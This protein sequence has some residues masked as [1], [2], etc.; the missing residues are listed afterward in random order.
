MKTKNKILIFLTITATIASSLVFAFRSSAQVVPFV[1]SFA[2]DTLQISAYVVNTEN[3]EIANGEYDVRFAIYS[4]DRTERDP[5]PSDTDLATRLWSETQKVKLHDGILSAYLGSVTPFPA[6]LRFNQGEYYIGIRIND[7]SEMIPRKRIAAVPAAVNAMYLRGVSY[8]SNQGDLLQLGTGG[9]IDI[10]YLNTGK[11]NNQLVL[12][13]DTRLAGGKITVGGLSYIKANGMK[14][15]LGQI[16]LG[17]DVTGTLGVSEGGTGLSSI[18]AGSVLY[19]NAS[20]S[21]T[22]LTGGV[23]NDGQMLSYNWNG[24][25]PYV[26]WATATG[27]FT[28][29][30]V[31]GDNLATETIINGNTLTIA[32]GTNI[33][34]AI[35]TPDTV[36][37]N[38]NTTLS[39][40]TWQGNAIASNYLASN[41]MLEGENISLLTNNSGYITASSADTLTNKSGNISMW[42]NNSGYITASSSDTLTNKTWNG[43]VIGPIYGGT[44]LNAYATG[45]ILYASGTDTLA[46]RHAGGNGAVLQLVGGVPNWASVN[47]VVAHDLLNS[48]AHQDTKAASP[49]LGALVSGIDDSGITKWGSVGIGSAIAKS[50]L[51]INSTRD[52][53]EWRPSTDIT[54]LGTVATG[55]WN[56]TPIADNYVAN[57]ITINQG[58]ISDS[59]I[60][61]KNTTG[62]TNEGEIE[63]DATGDTIKVGDGAGSQLTFYPGQ[64]GDITAVG[65]VASGPAFTSGGN[66]GTSLYFYDPD[67][68]GQLTVGNISTDRTY[69]LP[70]SSGNVIV[71]PGAPAQG[72]V[73]FYNG[74]NWARLGY[75]S[76]GWFLKTN[77]VGADPSWALAAGTTYS[78]GNGLTLNGTT[79]DLGGTLT[80]DATLTGAYNLVIDDTAGGIKMKENGSSPTYYGI[81]DVADLSSSDKTYTFPDTTGNVIVAP[82]APAQGDVLFYNGTNWARLGYGSSGWFLKTNGV[83][84]DPSWALA[85]GTTY[86]AGNGLTLNG[87]TFDLGGTLTTDAT[88]TGAYNLVIDDTAG[89]IKMKE[90]GSSPTYYGIFD[91]A[92]LSSSDKTYTFPDTTGNVI[93]A[94]GAPAQGDVLFYNGT[95]WARLGYGSSGWFLKTNGVGADPS[96]ALAAG[97]TYSAGNGLTLNGTTFDLGGTLTTDATLTGAYNLVIDDTAGGIKMKENGSSPTYYGIFDVADLSS[98]D[99]TYTFPDTT[100]N[101]IVAPGAPAQGDVLF[102]NGTNWA[103]LGYGSSGWFLKTN[104][105]GADPSWALAAG[106]T[107][108]A[109]NG[110]TLNGTTFDLGGTLTTD[111]TLTG[112]YNLVIDDTAGGIKMKENGSSPTYYGIFDVADLSSSDKTY[113][114]P[115]TTGNVIVAPGAPAQGDVLFYNG[116]NW[117]RLGYGSSGWFLKTN[118]VGAD[119]SWALAA[120]TTYSAGNGLTLNGTTF[121][122]GGTLTTDATLTG[123]YNLVIDDTAGG[124]KMKENGSSP[125]YYGIFD[126]ADLS[127]S[128]KTYTFPDTTGN[129]IVAPGAPAQGD[130]LFYNGTNWARLGYGSSGWFLKTNGVGAD[131]SWALAAGTTYSAGNGLTLNGTTFD[132]G[133][134]LTTDATLTGAYNL[135]IDDTAGGIKMKENGSSPTYYGIFDV[136]DLSSSDKT[137]TFPDTT[138]NVIVAPGAP[139]QGDVLFYN[140]TNWARLG[141][142]SSGWFLKTNGVGADPSWALAAGTTYSAGNGLT[143]NGTTFDLGGTLTTDATL[144]GAYNLVIDDTA[145]GIKMKENGSSPTYYGI[146]DVADLSSSDK[147]YTF[148]DTTGNVIVAPGAPAQGDVLFYNGTNWARLGYGSSGWFLKTNGVGAD[149]SWALA[150]GTTYSAGNGLTLNGTTFDLGGTLTTDATLTGAYN[151][152][153][154]DTAGGIKMKE[155]GSSPTYYGIFDVA[156]LSSSDKTYTFPDTTGNVIVAPGAPAQGDV[157]FYNGTNWARLGYGSSG[158]FLKTNGVGAD[159]SWALAAGTTYS[160]GNGLTLNGTTFD[161][162]GTLTTDAT[163]T[164]AYNLVIDD[165][166]GG[167]KMKENGSSPTYYGI[168]DVADLSSSDKTYTFPDTTGN[169]IVAPGAPAQGDVLFYNGTNWAR[170]GYGSSGWFLKT[171]GVGADPSWALAAGTTYS[172]GNG[173]TLNGTTF[174]LGGTLTTDAT[175]TGAYNLVIDDTAGGIKMK[176]NGS[177]PTY[178]G[179]FDVA[180]LS[181]SDKTYTFP[182]TTGNVIVAPGAPAQGDVLF[183][184]GTNWARLGYGSSGWFLKTNG[185]GADPS[186]ALAAGTTYS[187]GNGLTL[188]GTTFDLGGTLTTDAT[189]TGAYNLVIDDTAGGIKMKENGSSPTYYGIFDV[190]DLSSSDKTYTFPDTTGNVIVAPG[191]PAQGD[192]LFYN[193]TNWARLGYGSSGWFLKTNGVGADPSWALAAGTT[194]SAGNGLTLNGT[195]FDLGGTLTTDAT[196]TGA[197]NLVID[198]TA[199][200]IKMK[201]NGSSPTYYGIFDVADLSS[202]DKT[203]TFPD[204]TGNVIV[205]PGAP[206]Q[207]DVLFYNGTNW[208]RLGYGSSGWFLKTNGVGADPSWAL[209]AGTTYSAGNGLTLNGTTFDLGGTLTT[210]ATLTGAYNLVI[211]DTAGGI[212]MKENGSSPTYYGIFDVADLSSSDK[213]YTFPDTTGNVIVAPGAPAQGDVLF[214]NGTNWARLG[215]G[216]SGW[217]LKTNGVG[218]DPSWALAAGTTYSAGNGLTLNGTTFDLGGTLTT[219]ATLTGAYNLVID[220]T[221][222]GI[223][224]KENGSSPTY[225]GIFDVADL[226]SSDKTYTFPDTT[227]NVIVAPG[228]PAQGDVLFYNGTNWAR[229]GYGSSG[230]FLKTNGVGA[231]RFL[232]FGGRHHL[233]SR[234]R[235]HP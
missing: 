205:A 232:G 146:F 93:V 70:D 20:N 119:P 121:D 192:V 3:K 10:K 82:G 60:T 189:L 188:N 88:L 124:I 160:A 37:I 80:T 231:D 16:D 59:T 154:D 100:G 206:A 105:V 193:G 63:W 125:T 41:V 113:T 177:S 106:T 221:A 234:Q 54:A 127:S 92:D 115:D 96:W 122:L 117:A 137:Y 27:S 126:V 149:P 9:K 181:S 26:E 18:A 68:H 120:G 107:Y 123:A 132:L 64:G 138:G 194:Y 66:Q 61:L 171:N 140:G 110:L 222:G 190:A 173:L 226:S 196:L 69:I 78:A 202:S 223:K 185:V 52:A 118:G 95:N 51:M 147:T 136:A 200:G 165:T 71:A 116:T 139:A 90:N 14:L 167:I 75:G 58:S 161:L 211:D 57:N 85:A 191:A 184:N 21:L 174:D 84:A 130:V 198:D 13:N 114:F 42:T 8:G 212:K 134:T 150:A 56:A 207:G 197:Y 216:S 187:A 229:L 219:D 33:N 12:G 179:I 2:T 201:E 175:L 40:V 79:F 178:Y 24:G 166:A 72:D 109:G 172:A 47:Y 148:P 156:D 35:T 89:G 182:D 186:W 162:G 183:Y 73:L 46:V 128:D 144:T 99:K 67:G 133:G 74:T 53:I 210:D 62:S 168:F 170:L 164:G 233:L 195:T 76:S 225:Y 29:F 142:G 7:D 65:D 19:A 97:T 214:Y 77:G 6:T 159:P 235:P 48:L 218:A 230:W 153:I 141:Y 152:V 94:P 11:G 38:L 111:A 36:T 213:T 217:F 102:Y 23:G 227:G 30:D 208:A 228:A 55:V 45:D 31:T 22:A 220:D 28:S 15:T 43:A 39:G 209:A 32:G 1:S 151:L 98:S 87:T 145:G 101:V 25:S 157:L 199:G 131:P 108:S 176:E 103:R 155:N 50:I 49:T 5:Y 158:W 86:S 169:V 34:T 104:G 203:Y 135:V 4:K 180:D 163:L 81:F 112:A 129:V 91:V 17:T 224:M 215:Y 143:L 44:G 83:G 204:T